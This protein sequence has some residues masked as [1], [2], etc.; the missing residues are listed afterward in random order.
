VHASVVPG[1]PKEPAGQSHHGQG[2]APAESERWQRMTPASSRPSHPPTISARKG[3]WRKSSLPLAERFQ[4]GAIGRLSAHTLRR[5][6]PHETNT[7][8]VGRGPP[9]CPLP[10]TRG[11]PAGTEL[12]DGTIGGCLS[13]S[14]RSFGPSLQPAGVTLPHRHR[15]SVVAW[16]RSHAVARPIAIKVMNR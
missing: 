1:Q 9:A 6:P 11:R 4:S 14:S 5:C 3:I 13:H 10:A 16:A 12:E 15:H 8:C 7:V 2:P